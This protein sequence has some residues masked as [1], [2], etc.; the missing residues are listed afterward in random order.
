M[1]VNRKHSSPMFEHPILKGGLANS[2]RQY[3][4]R[5]LHKNQNCYTIARIGGDYA[6]KT[7]IMEIKLPYCSTIKYSYPAPERRGNS[8]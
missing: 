8:P 2:T 4:L 6:L 1:I 3:Q 5:Y 7:L